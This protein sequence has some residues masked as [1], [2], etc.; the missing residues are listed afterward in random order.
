[1]GGRYGTN[2]GAWVV[3]TVPTRGHGWQI[4]LT[5]C[6]PRTQGICAL[7]RYKDPGLR[8]WRVR[9]RLEVIY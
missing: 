5:R 3:D 1:M 4:R 9:S 6:Q 8:G 7:R 2:K